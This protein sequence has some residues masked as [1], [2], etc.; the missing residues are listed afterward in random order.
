MFT[1]LWEKAAKLEK[2]RLEERHGDIELS[3]EIEDIPLPPVCPPLFTS[4]EQQKERHTKNL[5][6]FKKLLS[7][8]TKKDKKYRYRLFPQSKIF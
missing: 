2:I 1:K 3:K 8:V 7:L 4:Q 5:V 6:N